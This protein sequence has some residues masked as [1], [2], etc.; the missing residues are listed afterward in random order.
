[1][2]LFLFIMYIRDSNKVRGHNW[3]VPRTIPSRTKFY[4][5]RQWT[6]P[7]MERNDAVHIHNK[8]EEVN[9][10]FLYAPSDVCVCV[11]YSLWVWFALSSDMVKEFVLHQCRAWVRFVF[12]F[13]FFIILGNGS[14]ILLWTPFF[15]IVVVIY[16]TSLN[17]YFTYDR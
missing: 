1:M 13:S 10:S 16:L 17:W 11:F 9:L 15:I 5:C 2:N 4:T 8:K 6:R 3:I 14:F 7:Q 12:P